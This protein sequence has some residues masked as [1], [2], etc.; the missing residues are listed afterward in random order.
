MQKKG[1]NV[2]TRYTPLPIQNIPPLVEKPEGRYSQNT[3]GNPLKTCCAAA[4]TTGLKSS[5]FPASAYHVRESVRCVEFIGG[6]IGKLVHDLL[7][8]S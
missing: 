1:E 7:Y 5:G 3:A 8:R 4:A 2:H 6:G